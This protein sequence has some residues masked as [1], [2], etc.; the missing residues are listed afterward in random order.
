MKFLCG[1]C[2]NEYPMKSYKKHLIDEH[3]MT[4]E[5]YLI[6]LGFN[7]KCLGCGCDTSIDSL[8]TGFKKY[9]KSCA[10]KSD[11][12]KDARKNTNLL[13]YG[14]TTPAGNSEVIKKQLKTINE[15]F[16]CHHLSLKEIQ[17]K[18][19]KTCIEKYGTDNIAK[20]VDYKN[21]LF[22]N[23]KNKIEEI[24][25]DEFISYDD[26]C[27][28]L[29]CKI[30]NNEYEIHRHLIAYRELHKQTFC[31]LCN[32]LHSTNDMQFE[33]HNYIKSIFNGEIIYNSRQIIKPLELDIYIPS[34]Q[35]AIEF[36]G[37]NWHS[38]EYVD[39][40]YH[41]NKTKECEKQSIHLIH[42]YEDDWL[43]KQDIVK[44]RLKSLLGFSD[45]TIGARKC[46]IKELDNKTSSKF[47]EEN[48][49]Q[50][51]GLNSKYRYGLY[52][53]NE[54]VAC[55]TFGSSRF[56]KGKMELHRFANKLGLNV[57]GGASRL[58]KY[59]INTVKTT[60]V[61]SYADRSWTMNNDKSVYKQLGFEL[62]KETTPNYYYIVNKRREDRFKFRK[63]EL[64]K[65]GFDASKT[66][67]EIMK[68]RKLFVIYDSGNLKYKYRI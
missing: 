52:F 50:G 51:G 48:H 54:L 26:S 3:N 7:N 39:K 29:R 4:K 38:S 18:R 8:T 24:T 19:K 31:T 45:R 13:K 1:I 21:I 30:C 44:S 20:A 35:V 14:S 55:M 25:G 63:S 40:R 65:E 22:N 57:S 66:E 58:F 28:K 2:N 53:E 6:S 15:R 42:I 33:V 67:A 5:Q 60:E 36:N 32:K 62:I 17:N 23:L 11:E 9:C 56:E 41:L 34:K 46:I 61:I 16:G 10:N 49:L 59:F 64:V 43:Y 27:R 47:L 68:R 12:V 37:L